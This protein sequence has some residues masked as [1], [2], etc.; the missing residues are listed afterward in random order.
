[1]NRTS[2]VQR[3]P[4]VESERS[5]P[6]IPST[7]PPVAQGNPAASRRSLERLLAPLEELAVG[8]DHFLSKSFG[9]FDS[10]GRHYTL[11]RYVYFGPRG[12]GDTLRIGIFA[13]IHG[14][15]PEGALALTRLVET[16]ERQ[17]DLA[18]GY[19]L[20]LYP[21]CNPTGFEDSTREA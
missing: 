14:D 2:S 5:A 21:V 7:L 15:E 8:S 11:P 16:L 17:P 3:R 1:M 13:T 10:D 4:A 20:F 6:Q 9:A 12:G 19:G 18:R